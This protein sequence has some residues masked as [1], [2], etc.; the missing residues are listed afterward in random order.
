LILLLAWQTR[1]ATIIM[2]TFNILFCIASCVGV[3]VLSTGLYN[4]DWFFEDGLDDDDLESDMQF[5]V[6]EHSWT[7]YTFFG[8]CVVFSGLGIFGAAYYESWMVLACAFWYCVMG[9]ASLVV[10]GLGGLGVFVA[11]FFAYPNIMFYQERTEDI[12]TQENYPGERYSCCCVAKPER[13]IT[14]REA[15]ENRLGVFS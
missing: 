2:N 13:K 6:Y 8:I 4:V 3:Y 9:I 10:L 1:R 11:G 7:L 12:M 14:I 15:I 5:L